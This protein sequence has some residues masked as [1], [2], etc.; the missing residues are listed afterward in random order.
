MPQS[1]NERPDRSTSAPGTSVLL[2]GIGVLGLLHLA[3]AW[4]PGIAV[5]GFDH[6]GALPVIVRFLLAL[7]VLVSLIPPVARAFDE[8]TESAASRPMF[9][10]ALLVAAGLVFFLFRSRALAYGDGYTYLGYIA[11]PQ[12]PH[13]TA[14]MFTQ[15]L[16]LAVH[17]G[18]HQ[19]L[20]APLGGSAETTCALL[21][22]AAG[23]VSLLAIF[24]IARHLAP[25]NAGARRLIMAA[26]LTSG[27]AILWFGY[28]EAYTLA[29]A[30]I[31]W[32]LALIMESGSRRRHL[33]AAWIVWAVACAFHLLA[34][35]FGPALLWGTWTATR[36]DRRPFSPLRAG[37]LLIGGLGL[38]ALGTTVLNLRGLDFFVPL[39]RTAESAYT[40]FSLAH[41]GDVGNQLILVAPLGL[42]GM[43]LWITHLGGGGGE[44]SAK[45][46]AA[47]G[48]LAVAAAGGWYFSFWVDPLLGGFRDWDL[49]A[50]FGI[51]LSLWAVTFFLPQGREAARGNWRW[52]PVAALAV[53]HV[54]PFAATLQDE[55]EAALRV[56][57]YL[58][59][60]MHYGAEFHRGERLRSWAGIVSDQLER[61]DLAIEHL[62]RRVSF[63][64]DDPG[65]WANLGSAYRFIDRFDSA[66]AC[67]KRA[68]ELDPNRPSYLENLG[69]LR[70]WMRDYE[71][72]RDAFE[73]EVAVTD[74]GYAARIRLAQV[75]LSLT[76]PLRADTLLRQ[77]V[78]L[79]PDL[80]GAYALLGASAE[81][82]AEAEE[83]GRH[84]ED[85]I[86]RGGVNDDIFRRLAQL[87]QWS[88]ELEEALAVTRRWEE[89]LPSSFLAP[90]L[91]GTTFIRMEQY[92][93]A[94]VALQRSLIRTPENALT[95]Y[96][97]ATTYRHLDQPDRA[98][99]LARL[100]A[101]L[102]TTLALP[103][104]ELL[105]LAADA[106]DRA[107]A[108]AATR[109]FLRRSPADSGMG[110]LQQFLEP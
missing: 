18:T 24:R 5:W 94:N 61:H 12:F 46:R 56:D 86:A 34:L 108:V 27:T 68:S 33:V 53:V 51:P 96:Y 11:A 55:T 20:I 38:G 72:A 60:D 101:R 50:A 104:L 29:N 81:N 3:A 36:R 43:A 6:W 22:A 8:I 10:P 4:I 67:F 69:V 77:A 84:Y 28:I 89:L 88:G 93:S 110:Y 47:R 45:L 1:R 41:L 19:F 30:A 95:T 31:L 26:A 79:H 64:P 102:D 107:G 54:G 40:A 91:R 85:A 62:G 21:G 87:H 90:L 2:I 83:A 66:A 99:E 7:I 106:D 13:I 80:P 23:V 75:Y 76:Q 109:E 9:V 15:T 37:A 103:Y 44:A 39:R 98:R 49:L 105:Y 82:R 74:T 32:A 71:G 97:L 92:D 35:A 70:T 48:T 16:D 58:R 17:W 100:A 63:V 52:I 42:I 78:A 59:E 25:G 73:R 14:Q 57:A 65:D